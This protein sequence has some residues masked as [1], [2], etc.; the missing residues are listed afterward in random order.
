MTPRY[1][2]RSVVAENYVRLMWTPK[3]GDRILF[4]GTNRDGG[5]AMLKTVIDEVSEH[6]VLV[7]AIP[8]RTI[9]PNQFSYRVD[10]SEYEAVLKKLASLFQYCEPTTPGKFVVGL[11]LNGRVVYLKGRPRKILTQI[12]ELRPADMTLN[13]AINDLVNGPKAERGHGRIRLVP[14]QHP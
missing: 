5:A 8:G 1:N 7:N 6:G 11:K 10:P 2:R 4:L 3:A 9:E 14:M 13:Q 12:L